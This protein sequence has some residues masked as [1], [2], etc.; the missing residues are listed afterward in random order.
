M[1]SV[2][3]TIPWGFPSRYLV[4]QFSKTT[5]QYTFLKLPL[6]SRG[7]ELRCQ[8]LSL[9]PV[10]CINAV[11]SS[12]GGPLQTDRLFLRN[13]NW[14]TT[15]HQAL[16]P[17][18]VSPLISIEFSAHEEVTNDRMFTIPE[19]WPPLP[20][21]D[22]SKPNLDFY[23]KTGRFFQQRKVRRLLHEPHKKEKLAHLK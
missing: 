4:W 3:Q 22:F 2:W 16:K 9:S 17:Y 13:L 1:L 21:H 12:P 19:K 5:A 23:T 6:A 10:L 18:H 8:F 14:L 11:S 15:C 20:H 7:W